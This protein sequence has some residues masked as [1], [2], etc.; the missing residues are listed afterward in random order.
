MIA[1]EFRFKGLG[2]VRPCLKYG[3]S[4]RGKGITLKY[5]ERKHTTGPRLS[6]MVSK[7]VSKRA[8]VRNRI[9]RRIMEAARP[10]LQQITGRWDLVI[11]VYDQAYADK[12]WADV[13]QQVG[14]LLDKFK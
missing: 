5:L 2:S 8:V 11:T 6:V 7:K 4:V 14:Q 9:R 1:K 3:Q 13:E 10:H 12:P